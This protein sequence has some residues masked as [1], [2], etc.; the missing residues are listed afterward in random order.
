MLL[1]GVTPL[2]FADDI[3]HEPRQTIISDLSKQWGLDAL[4]IPKSTNTS[5]NSSAEFW[6]D[7]TLLQT[8]GTGFKSLLPIAETEQHLNKI[9]G[10]NASYHNGRF[11]AQTG[12]YSQSTNLTESGQ[13]YLQSSYQFIQHE[14][15]NIAVTAKLE[16]LDNQMMQSYIGLSKLSEHTSLLKQSHTNASV[17]IE[18]QFNINKNWQITGAIISTAFEHSPDNVVETNNSHMALFST[19]YSF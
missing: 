2:C 9:N 4:E 10:I 7:S 15:F 13:I 3:N 14:K 18:T 17:S 5:T 16:A 6:L 1:S 19:S 12:I 11:S 8:A